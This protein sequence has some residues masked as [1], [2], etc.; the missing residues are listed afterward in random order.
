MWSLVCWWRQIQ[1]SWLS[2]QGAEKAPRSWQSSFVWVETKDKN[3]WRQG[4]QK[5]TDEMTW[6][7]PWWQLLGNIAH[8]PFYRQVL[9]EHLLPFLSSLC[10][11][12]SCLGKST[13]FMMS[14]GKGALPADTL[15]AHLRVPPLR[16]Y[17]H[18][19]GLTGTN[20][21]PGGL[22]RVLRAGALGWPW[23]MGWEGRWE[24]GSGWGTHVHP[25]L[26]HVNVWQ[27]PLQY[28]K[29]ISLQLK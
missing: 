8:H 3:L 14:R 26:I 13:R 21:H 10:C 20:Q 24:R 12:L 5:P 2:H 27:K 29:V 4:F 9:G 25:W 19:P 16:V 6:K 23:R 11:A 17:S 28:C 15:T 22:K 18:L 1:G 7:G